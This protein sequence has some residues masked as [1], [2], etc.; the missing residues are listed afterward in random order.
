MKKPIPSHRNV[1]HSRHQD[2]KR[3]ARS[4]S[5][6]SNMDLEKEI[7]PCGISGRPRPCEARRPESLDFPKCEEP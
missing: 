6:A 5:T 7:Y 3:A 4:D 2:S 1:P